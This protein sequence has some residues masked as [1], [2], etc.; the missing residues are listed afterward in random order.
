MFRGITTSRLISPFWIDTC[1]VL[2]FSCLACNVVILTIRKT[3]EQA[4]AALV[5]DAKL[6]CVRV[7]LSLE[8]ILV[9]ILCST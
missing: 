8:E 1:F 3:Y 7:L 4:E 9:R 6:L 5:L 2:L